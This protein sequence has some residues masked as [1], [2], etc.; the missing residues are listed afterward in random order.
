MNRWVEKCN[1]LEP[2]VKKTKVGA[3]ATPDLEFLGSGEVAAGH[4]GGQDDEG[5]NR[6]SE[7]E[8]I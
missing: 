2:R 4:D 3:H 8:P 1:F 7:R 5:K 6:H